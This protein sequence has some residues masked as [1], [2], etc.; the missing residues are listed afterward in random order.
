M[1]KTEIAV[2]YSME[3]FIKSHFWDLRPS[4][5]LCSVIVTH[6]GCYVA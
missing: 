2:E 5:M 3:T 1:R 6:L 4:G